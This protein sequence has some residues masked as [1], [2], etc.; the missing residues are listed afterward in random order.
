[1]PDIPRPFLSLL[2][3]SKPDL[4]WLT[5]INLV[6]ETGGRVMVNYPDSR[7]MRLLSQGVWQG[8]SLDGGEEGKNSMLLHLTLRISAIYWCKL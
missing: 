8:L 4:V 1:M 7:R 2:S 6:I 5:M 3:T